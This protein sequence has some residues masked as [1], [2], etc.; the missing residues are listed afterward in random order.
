MSLNIITHPATTLPRK[1]V[2][3]P[4]FAINSPPAII[5]IPIGHVAIDIAT[6]NH[7]IPEVRGHISSP[8]VHITAIIPPIA[9]VA[10][11]IRAVSFG[12][13]SIQFPIFSITGF[14][15]ITSLF[16]SGN[17]DSPIF[18]HMSHM[19][20]FSCVNQ[21]VPASAAASALH[22]YCFSS[23]SNIIVCASASWFVSTKALI[24]A[25]WSS[26]NCIP[27]LDSADRFATGSFSAL[28]NCI[29]AD[30]RSPSSRVA[31]SSAASCVL[32]KFLPAIFVN[33]S[34]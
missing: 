25:F 34:N 10:L 5:I 8:S 11:N 32:S 16:S 2:I 3:F 29:L 12:F 4:Q 6:H 23:S 22:Q 13:S 27:L 15:E 31:R 9:I 24:V 7:A 28:P 19:E 17:K 18:S 26:E 30:F 14:K 20:F 1:S 33:V 21:P